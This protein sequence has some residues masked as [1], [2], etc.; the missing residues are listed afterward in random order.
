MN[1]NSLNKEIYDKIIN[2]SK[3]LLKK[4]DDKTVSLLPALE[5]LEDIKN[6]NLDAV[7]DIY[8]YE[9]GFGNTDVKLK[10]TILHAIV[11]ILSF[12]YT[13][14]NINYL[15]DIILAEDN[16]KSDIA[17]D[18]FLKIG[19]YH[20]KFRNDV[21]NFIEINLNVF[22]KNK[23]NT[24]GF[25]LASVYDKNIE[26]FKLVNDLHSQKYPKKKYTQ[27]EILNS[28]KNDK[29]GDLIHSSVFIQLTSNKENFIREFE[30]VNRVYISEQILSTLIDE[31]VI[32][33]KNS[34]IID[35]NKILTDLGLA[36]IN[37]SL[38][39][40]QIEY[41]INKFQSNLKKER[42]KL[43]ET[44]AIIYLSLSKFNIEEII[45]LFKEKKDKILN[46]YIVMGM[47]DAGIQKLF[48]YEII[49]IENKL[50]DFGWASISDYIDL[51]IKLKN[52]GENTVI[53]KEPETKKENKIVEINNNKKW[54]E[55]WK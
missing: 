34:E 15:K 53:K 38:N 42:L 9:D 41:D 52:Q 44:K 37:L 18:Y 13:I 54:W 32:D 50:T 17:L 24:I 7:T 2:A 25:Y 29:N 10:N 51:Q 43:D 8:I 3:L 47:S 21:L 31:V 4:E 6:T 5:L 36:H 22:T 30:N 20:E 46:G 40:A 49:T 16:K 23:L 39:T 33:F 48:E 1:I 45:S 11:S 35:E 55:F 27:D 28:L 14:E 26:L 19:A 12:D